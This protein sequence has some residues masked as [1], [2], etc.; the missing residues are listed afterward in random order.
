M[1]INISIVLYKNNLVKIQETVQNC[2]NENLDGTI[3]LVDNSESEELRIISNVDQRINYIF[4]NSNL[5]Y[6]KAHNIAIRKSIFENVKYHLVMNPDISF[7]NGVLRL[8]YDFME[9]NTQVGLV[10]PKVLYPNGDMQYLRKLLPTPLNLFGRRFFNFRYFKK[11]IER[12]NE[13]YETR[14]VDYDKT[15]EAPYLSGC[16]M[17]MRTKILKRIGLFDERFFMYL[18]DTDLSRRIHNV[19]KTIYYPQVYVYHGFEKGSFKDFKL[20]KFHVASTIR[21][22]NKWGWFFDKK[23]K[24]INAKVIKNITALTMR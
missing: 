17:F 21:Y 15:I 7:D 11:F 19:A 10:M 8:L 23:R 22:F 4:N 16:F 2:L 5:G 9:N 1:N 14:F 20:F 18:E 12:Y 3:Y 6:G 13:I 24:K